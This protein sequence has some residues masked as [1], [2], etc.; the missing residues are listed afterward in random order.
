MARLKKEVYTK[1]EVEL[2]THFSVLKLLGT[3]NN[4]LLSSGAEPSKEVGEIVMGLAKTVVGSNEKAASLVE[5]LQVDEARAA[6]L[7]GLIDGA[8]K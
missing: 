1:E 7:Q 6:H 5:S 2:I 3:V 4:L 8:L